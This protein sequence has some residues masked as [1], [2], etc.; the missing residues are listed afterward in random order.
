MRDIN[1]QEVKIRAEDLASTAKNMVI[2]LNGR[3]FDLGRPI[4]G[5]GSSVAE[6]VGRIESA[7]GLVAE[8]DSSARSDLVPVSMLSKLNDSITN[9]MAAIASLISAFEDIHKSHGGLQTFDYSDF[10]A[11]T[12]NGT[13]IDMQ[14]SFHDVFDNSEIF[15]ERVLI[16]ALMLKPDGAFTFQ[17]AAQGLSAVISEASEKLGEL[18]SSISRVDDMVVKLA[19]A[20]KESSSNLQR[21]KTSVEEI[22]RLKDEE[23]ADRQTA[24]DYLAEITQHRAAAQAIIDEVSPLQARFQE[25]KAEFDLFQEQLD[26]RE[27]AFQRGAAKL[28]ELIGSF[29]GQRDGVKALID[30]S[31]QMMSSATVSG[32]AANFSNVAAKLTRELRWARFAFYIGILFL[33]IS[34]FPLLAFALPT[35]MTSFPENFSP[36]VLGTTLQAEVGGT[37]N[38][39]EYVGQVLA[40]I[41]ILLPAAWFIS[42]TA[43]RHSE[44]FRLREHYSYKSSMAVAVE[45]FKLQAPRYEQEIAVAVLE[46]LALNPADSLGYQKLTKDAKGSVPAGMFERIRRRAEKPLDT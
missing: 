25:Y 21:S 46:Q 26:R 19:A 36:G 31:Q 10:L 41:V 15:L 13:A 9:S 3:A 37:Q 23:V 8:F 6:I 40:R 18:K 43:K 5:R 17:S 30:R 35:V 16:S 45:G 22:E 4:A 38:G 34:A 24:S 20:E 29:E 2:V 14:P 7:V 32:L 12:R 28:E 39:L 1:I 27:E 33:V 42:F 11:T 44:L